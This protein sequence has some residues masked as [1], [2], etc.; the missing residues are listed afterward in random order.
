LP[1]AIHFDED[2]VS[3]LQGLP[4]A[5]EHR[6]ADTPILIVIE[7][8]QALIANRLFNESSGTIRARVVD[9][10]NRLYLGSDPFYDAFYV[11]RNFVAWDDHGDAKRRE[12]GIMSNG[13]MKHV[14][15]AA[16]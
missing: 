5:R 3:V 13:G 4:V 16:T 15:P 6:A 14:S 9:T 8:P 10:V 1:I 12:K 7:N 2:V 11:S